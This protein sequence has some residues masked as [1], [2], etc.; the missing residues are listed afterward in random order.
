MIL[1]I[2]RRDKCDLIFSRQL[3]S[4]FVSLW[5]LQ[6]MDNNYSAQLNFFSLLFLVQ[7]KKEQNT[8]TTDWILS[9]LMSHSFI[10]T[11]VVKKAFSFFCHFTLY[12]LNTR[13]KL[14]CHR[15]YKERPKRQVMFALEYRW[16]AC[17]TFRT[18]KP[19]PL[20]LININHEGFRYSPS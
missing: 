1:L 10:K 6:K 18:E 19:A 5:S 11:E 3:L 14:D 9:F 15:I 16:T 4:C 2:T 17:R 12:R 7:D 8:S 20:L 13:F